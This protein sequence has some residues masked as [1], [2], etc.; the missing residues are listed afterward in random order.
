ME[1]LARL[2]PRS[3]RDK[4]LEEN[5]IYRAIPDPGDRYMLAAFTVW[6]EF[7]ERDLRDEDMQCRICLG[8]I[9]ENMT[10]LQPH[11]VELA[12]ADKLLDL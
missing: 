5:I 12:R 7:V 2:I 3:T 9:L 11:L 4:L 6:K 1:Q 8:R 10:A